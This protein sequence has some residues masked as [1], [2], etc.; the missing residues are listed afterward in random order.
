[1]RRHDKPDSPIPVNPHTCLSSP[2]FAN[3]QLKL[4][5]INPRKSHYPKINPRK[6]HST[7]R[8]THVS[9]SLP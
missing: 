9:L 6:S 8:L 4:L 3:P 2:W 7:L 5:K 1:M